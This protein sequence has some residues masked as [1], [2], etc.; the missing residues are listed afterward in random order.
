MIVNVTISTYGSNFTHT[1]IEVNRID[2]LADKIETSMRDKAPL[3][4]KSLEN[5]IAIIPSDVLQKSKI[6]ITPDE[7]E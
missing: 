2:T 4:L 6:I 3:R 5:S 7:N 1:D